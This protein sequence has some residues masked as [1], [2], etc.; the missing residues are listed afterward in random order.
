MEFTAAA[1]DKWYREQPGSML[2]EMEQAQLDGI[3]TT[4][5]G[6]HLLQIGG[7]SHLSLVE[8]SPIK[9]KTLLNRQ[10]F[11]IARALQIQADPMALPISPNSVDLVLVVHQLAFEAQPKVV[12][13]EI[14]QAL[15]PEGIVIIL[16]FNPW[17]MWNLAHLNKKNSF[18]WRGKF[19]SLWRINKYLRAVGFR[20]ITYKTLG[21][22][23]PLTNRRLAKQILFMEFVGQICLPSFGAAYMVVAQKRVLA[24]IPIKE[25]LWSHKFNTINGYV[26]STTRNIY[27]D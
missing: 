23:P 20:V 6:S 21:F 7:P 13:N 26:E 4:I 9:H 24:K 27:H 16:G 11:L 25:K 19:W 2:L 18:P 14:Y 17:S 5:K 10:S 1:M 22:R 15:R 3:L 8:S 12:L